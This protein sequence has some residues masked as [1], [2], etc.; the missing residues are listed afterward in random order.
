M[1]LDPNDENIILSIPEDAGPL[2]KD[3]ASMLT[4]KKVHIYLINY[5]DANTRPKAGKKLPPDLSCHCVI[6]S[7]HK[8]NSPVSSSLLLNIAEKK[9]LASVNFLFF[10]GPALIVIE[11]TDYQ[12]CLWSFH[13]VF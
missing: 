11:K 10:T 8:Q 4:P 13:E 3:N 6:W 9:A 1:Q 2:V 12:L 5:M 7:F